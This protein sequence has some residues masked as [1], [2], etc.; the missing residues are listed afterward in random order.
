MIEQDERGAQPPGSPP[1]DDS[2]P[3]FTAIRPSGDP[4][5]IVSAGSVRDCWNKLAA[6]S[7]RSI[8]ELKRGGWR[9]ARD[10]GSE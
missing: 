4:M 10:Q 5:R 2:A 3:V 1:D 6:T 7:G 8:A 9:V